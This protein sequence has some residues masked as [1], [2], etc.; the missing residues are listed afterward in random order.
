MPMSPR[1]LRP[2]ASGVFDPR[3][4]SG[5]QAWW[6][7]FDL[8]TLSQTS[9][10]TT[11]I[12]GNSQPVA[13]IRDRVNGY[14]MTQ[15]TNNNRPTYL[16]AGINGYPALDFDGV[17]DLL[18][19]SSGGVLSIS[20]NVGGLT[21]FAAFSLDTP[22]AAIFSPVVFIGRGN[23]QLSFATRSGI[24]ANNNLIT[25]AGRRLDSDAAIIVSDTA[26]FSIGTPYV[27]CAA[28]NY[29]GSIARIFRDGIVRGTN[30]A[31]HSGGNTDNTDSRRVVLFGIDDTS[32]QVTD[33]RLGDVLVYNRLLS[34]AEIS[35]VNRWLGSRYGVTVA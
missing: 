5:L 31:F 9:D 13:Y 24:A 29:S 11:A 35:T 6:T 20:R 8:A 12:T 17:N 19:S 14:A 3:A 1:L 32:G 16:S 27:A 34:D 28:F 21:I 25:A 26:N 30:T 33:G 18:F 7:P 4:I 10:G 22:S 15:T 23:E 2:R